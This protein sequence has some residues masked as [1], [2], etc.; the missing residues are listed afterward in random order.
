MLEGNSN[1]REYPDPRI[2]EEI[3]RTESLEENLINVAGH[4][5]LSLSLPK[6]KNYILS[7]LQAQ[8]EREVDEA[9]RAL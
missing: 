7:Y 5:T 2:C 9:A 6:Y 3:S 4:Q 8:N 1:Y